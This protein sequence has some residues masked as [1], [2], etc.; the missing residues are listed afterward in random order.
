[1]PIEIGSWMVQQNL[2]NEG[3]LRQVRD[4]QI[5][6]GGELGRLMVDMGL[7]DERRLATAL[8]QALGIPKVDLGKLQGD[9]DAMS[10]VPRRLAQNLAVF[11]CVMRDGGRT[12][13]LA[14]ANPL[15]DNAKSAVERAAKCGVK[16]TVAG[17]REIEA[18]IERHYAWE[19]VDEL[20]LADEGTEG[21]VKITDMSGKTMITFAPTAP[22]KPTPPV[23]DPEPDPLDPFAVS[24]GAP[25]P[26]AAFGPEELKLLRM[27]QEGVTKS[28]QALQA[29]LSLCEERG[30]LSRA[31]LTERL[32]R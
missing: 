22:P 13:W 17:Y 28:A 2:L 9:A 25:S 7:V 10:K 5:Q 11:P 26:A 12:L 18:A 21:P 8:S 15:D 32:K 31:E 23:T 20:G 29:V 14:M 1:M 3:Q 4:V 24:P 16:V 30:L 19:E 6:K 27:L